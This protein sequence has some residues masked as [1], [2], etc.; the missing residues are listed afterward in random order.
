MKKNIKEDGKVTENYENGEYGIYNFINGEK[1][2]TFIL[3]YKNGEIILDLFIK[4]DHIKN[5]EKSFWA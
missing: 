2:G 4:T 3:Y 1:H 5:S